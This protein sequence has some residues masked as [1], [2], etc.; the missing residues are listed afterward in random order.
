MS[1]ETVLAIWNALRER[2]TK[3]AAGL[4]EEDLDLGMG[5]SSI[6]S[7]LYHTA[8]VEYMFAD[9]YLEKMMP[10]E[11][12]KAKNLP[13]LLDLLAASDENLKQAMEELTIE[14]WQTPVETKMGVST[15]LEAIGRLMYH[16]GI[17]AGQIALM[18]NQRKE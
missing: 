18:K 11:L 14:Q 4:A 1:D 2:F 12:S 15:P 9:W 10:A 8:E 3:M 7:L 17:H 6:R 13:E 16:A 5:Q